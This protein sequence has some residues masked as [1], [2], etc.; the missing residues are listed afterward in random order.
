MR[1]SGISPDVAC[2]HSALR[3]A[4]SPGDV[5]AVLDIMSTSGVD[6]TVPLIV[7]AVHKLAHGGDFEGARC[8]IDKMPEFGCVA[9]VVVYT[10]LFDGMRAFGDVDAAM[11]LLEEM[12]GGGL[13]AG[14]APNVV[15]YTCL[16]KCLCERGRM[17]EALSVLDRMVARGV[18]PNRVFV[19]TLVDGFCASGGDGSLDSAYDV[20]ERL[21][22]D[23]ALS[24]GQ[25]YNVL[26][27]ALSG[28]GMAGEAEGLA[29]R[30]MKKG[31]QL[32]PLGG[33]AMVRELCRSKRWLDACYWLRLMDDDGVLCDSDV[34]ASVLLG[35]SQEGHVLEASAL[36]RKAMDKGICIEASRADYLV[37]LLKQH[38]DEELAS[39][40]LGL[41]RSPQVLS[42]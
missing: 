16:V 15:S 26:L 36:V 5:S 27:V 38:G 37:Q 39:H 3:V 2:F 23:G 6:P 24:S 40:V 22:V 8:L 17:V 31:V 20:V 41:R 18:M 32:S 19:R 7:T 9:S 34:Y 10:A 29:Q 35:L 11:G 28:A 4:G 12:E 13:G 21:V 25:C 33:S 1:S 30:M 14:C 42:H